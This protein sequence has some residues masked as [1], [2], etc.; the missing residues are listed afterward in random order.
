[1][2]IDNY[3]LMETFR[4]ELVKF[5]SYYDTSKNDRYFHCYIDNPH[6][7]NNLINFTINFTSKHSDGTL[8]IPERGI[9][10]I[11]EYLRKLNDI[12]ENKIDQILNGN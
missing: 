4:D 6:I 5:N 9:V 10:S 12:R 2:R 11:S 7:M 8:Y 1:M 3:I